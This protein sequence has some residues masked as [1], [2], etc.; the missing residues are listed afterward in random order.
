MDVAHRFLAHGP[1][2]Q[3][4]EDLGRVIATAHLHRPADLEFV[5][6]GTPIP[7]ARAR[8]T[9]DREQKRVRFFT[10]PKSADYRSRVAAEAWSAAKWAPGTTMERRDPG[11]PSGD[12][13]AR[14][15]R[16]SRKSKSVRCR[17]SWCATQ[18]RLQVLFVMPDR[19][20]RDLD[21]C[22]KNI[23]DALTGVIYHDDR[24]AF[25]QWKDVAYNRENPRIEVKVRVHHE[26]GELE[27]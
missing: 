25:V 7:Y 14:T 19:R 21:N 10:D 15:Q 23:L 16:R 6:H 11:W 13:C 20:T 2:D 24:Q 9:Y 27:L 8:Q 17:C 4:S 26:Q 18:Y 22:E 3:T 12:D 1:P 5:V